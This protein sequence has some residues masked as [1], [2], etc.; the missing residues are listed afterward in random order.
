VRQPVLLFAVELFPNV[1]PIEASLIIGGVGLAV[2]RGG[3]LIAD[4]EQDVVSTGRSSPHPA[5]RSMASAARAIGLS[6]L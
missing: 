6:M 1:A 3:V 2:G 5:S 4:P